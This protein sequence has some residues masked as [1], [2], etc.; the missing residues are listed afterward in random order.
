MDAYDD[1]RKR[2]RRLRSAFFV[3]FFSPFPCTLALFA[4]ARAWGNYRT[5]L[6]AIPLFIWS[7]IV[8]ERYQKFPCPRC[9]KC[10]SSSWRKWLDLSGKKCLHCGLERFTLASESAWLKKKPE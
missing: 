10:F 1:Q 8:Y 2:Y 5:L 7:S 3:S 6:L 9:G 4:L